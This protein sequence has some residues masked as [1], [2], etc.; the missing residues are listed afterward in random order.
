MFAMPWK[1]KGLNLNEARFPQSVRQDDS[2]HITNFNKVEE[3]TKPPDY[4]QE[5]ELITLMDKH[6]IGTDASIPQHIK[7]IQ[8]R[9]YVDVCGPGIDG[10]RGQLIKVNKFFGKNQRGGGRPQ[11]QDR[12]TSRH[13]VPRGFGLSFLACFEDLDVELCEPGIRSYMEQQV[14]NIA[15][16]ETEK[17]E[18]VSSNLKLFRDKFLYFR[19][20]MEKVNRYFAP[21]GQFVNSGGNSSTNNNTQYNQRGGGV[22][23]RGGRGRG[24]GGFSSENSN[25]G[26]RNT[27]NEQH[28][29]HQS[30]RGGYQ[31]QRGS[32]QPQ[33]GNHQPQQGG[34]QRHGGHESGQHNENMRQHSEPQQQQQQHGANLNKRDG[35]DNGNNRNGYRG[36]QG[37]FRGGYRGGSARGG[38]GRGVSSD[39]GGYHGNQGGSNQSARGRGTLFNSNSSFGRGRE[40]IQGSTI[41]GQKRGN[42]VAVTTD[43][44]KRQH[45]SY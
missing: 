14:Q 44:P 32:H 15:T 34:C 43:K 19:D 42:S 12:P 18:V 4:L 45:H 11:Q 38:S 40:N 22:G 26:Y 39:R 28:H 13:M 30:Q 31:P 24:R 25:S 10:E 21:K 36:N 29:Q 27:N 20:H 37:N 16:G 7:N 17:N 8:E 2:V 33:R 1:L 5:S 35:F 6:G 41:V 23:A 3:F 9:H